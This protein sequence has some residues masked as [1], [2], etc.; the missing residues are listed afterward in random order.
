MFDF[1]GF[2]GT[3]MWE[4]G[5]RLFHTKALSANVS[6]QGLFVLWIPDGCL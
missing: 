2:A 4:S 3:A 6:T 1:R 5:G